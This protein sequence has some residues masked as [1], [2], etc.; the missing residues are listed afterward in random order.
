MKIIPSSKRHRYFARVIIF[1]LI[2]AGLIVCMTGCRACFPEQHA[3]IIPSTKCGS[4]T[5]PGEK[6]LTYDEGTVVDLVAEAG[7]GH[8][9]VE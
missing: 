6:T 3:L 7:E 2:V 8:R 5:D 1:F 9:F 4:V